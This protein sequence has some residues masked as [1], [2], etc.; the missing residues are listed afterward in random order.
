MKLDEVD[1]TISISEG[2]QS[3][4]K[5]SDYPEVIVRKWKSYD[6]KSK[7]VWLQKLNFSYYIKIKE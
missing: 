7:F 6:P 4:A 5:N 3:E 1:T 2:E